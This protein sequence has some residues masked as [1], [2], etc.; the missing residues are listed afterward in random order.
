MH[1]CRFALRV[2]KIN[3]CDK[4]KMIR[5]EYAKTHQRFMGEVQYLLKTFQ[6][7]ITYI[8]F[9]KPNNTKKYKQKSLNIRIK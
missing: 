9:T 3:L 5:K 8:I 6:S 1:F 7:I 2:T 4:K